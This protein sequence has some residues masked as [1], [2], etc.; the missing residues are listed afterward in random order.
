MEQLFLN[1]KLQQQSGHVTFLIVEKKLCLRQT[2]KWDMTAKYQSLI[3]DK[4]SLFYLSCWK[5][6]TYHYY[7]RIYLCTKLKGRLHHDVNHY[8]YWLVWG[9]SQAILWLVRV[10]I[11]TKAIYKRTNKSYCL[12]QWIN[13]TQ[14]ELTL[15]DPVRLPFGCISIPK[16]MF[17]NNVTSFHSE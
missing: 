15:W 7:P 1:L 5:W 2:N 9:I 16:A 6:Q 12:G 10:I 3:S 8:Y 17:T 11:K 13:L 14:S 4:V